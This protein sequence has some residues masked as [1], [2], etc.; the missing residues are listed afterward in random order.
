M[1]KIKALFIQYYSVIS[2][3]F[4][5]GLTTLINI[6]VFTVLHNMTTWN[7]QVSN[8]LAWFLS[9]LFAYITNKLWVFNSKTSTP[10]AFIQEISSFFFF[11][12]V[13]LLFDTL[14]M[15]VGISLLGGNAIL[16]KIIDNVLIV[17]INYVF[18]K[19]FIFK[20]SP[21]SSS[22]KQED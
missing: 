6:G 7:Y 15:W 20:S 22:K 13:S 14:I 18:S 11:R 21:L 10:K 8:V 12:I 19:L 4:F 2:Y 1:K 3:L 5:G 9:V 16:V 17:I